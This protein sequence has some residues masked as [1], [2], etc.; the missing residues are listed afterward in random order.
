MPLL[1]LGDIST[2]DGFYHSL[3]A[4]RSVM[5]WPRDADARRRYF[6]KVAAQHLG[7][8][9]KLKMDLPDPAQAEN[10][11]ETI[12][13]CEELENWHLAYVTVSRLFREAGGFIAV[14]ESSPITE[15]QQ[16]M[17]ERVGPWFAAGMILALIRRMAT[18]HSDIPGGPSVNK[19][20][21][22]LEHAHFP[23]VPRNS[24]YLRMAWTNYKPVAHL[25][26]ALFDFFIECLEE[27]GSPIEIGAKMERKLNVEFPAFL[28]TADA[29]Q[30]FGLNYAPHRAKGQPLLDSAEAWLL[31]DEKQW[32]PTPYV[33]APLDERLLELARRYRAPIP[34]A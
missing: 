24:R 19:A 22:V 11:F 23:M 34:T 27:G 3:V 25:C 26:A 16:Q 7:A 21:F 4:V 31:P 5:V 1:E 28:A 14:A 18:H 9:E 32:A 30:E 15:Y 17:M 2:P 10:W 6:A 29:Y 20:M 13:D 8:L 33:P 12:A